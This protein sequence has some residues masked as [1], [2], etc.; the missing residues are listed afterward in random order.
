MAQVGIDLTAFMPSPASDSPE[1]RICFAFNGGWCDRL[2]I[3]ME[4]NNHMLFT[5]KRASAFRPRIL[6]GTIREV[7][8]YGEPLLSYELGWWLA[9]GTATWLPTRISSQLPGAYRMAGF[10]S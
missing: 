5:M 10:S 8:G 4:R 2:T 6:R 7:S 9:D 3:H 1:H